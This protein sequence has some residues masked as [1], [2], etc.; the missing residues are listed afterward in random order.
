[1]STIG[2]LSVQ[3]QQELAIKLAEA[4]VI[5]R[6]AV[7]VVGDTKTPT[8]QGTV[9]EIAVPAGGWLDTKTLEEI[10]QRIT[11][12]NRNLQL[13]AYEQGIVDCIKAIVLLSGVVA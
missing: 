3:K 5:L 13:E 9:R 6:A 11:S 2:E 1:M 7:P 4:L 10:D 12:I 8:A